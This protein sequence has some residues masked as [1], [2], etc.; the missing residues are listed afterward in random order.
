MREEEAIFTGDGRQRRLGIFPGVQNYDLEYSQSHIE[1][2]KQKTAEGHAVRAMYMCSAM[3]DLAVECEDTEMLE[4][5]KRLWDSTVNHRMYLTGGIGSSGFG[6]GLPRITIA[7]YH[8][9]F[10]DLCFHRTDDVRTEDEC[11]HRRG[12]LLRYR[13]TGIVQYSVGGHQQSGRQILYVNPLEVVPEFCTEHTYMDREGCQTEMVLRGMLSAECGEDVS[14][15][16]TIHLRTGRKCG[17]YPPV[18]FL[19]CKGS[20]GKWN[21]GDR[22]GIH[23]VAG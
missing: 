8:E 22:H 13:G 11:S 19:H 14:V 18:H 3:A 16:W 12:G 17:M 4:A 20:P 23:T 7:E 21:R 15:S 2:V 5:C 1:P 6:R 10:G 9:L